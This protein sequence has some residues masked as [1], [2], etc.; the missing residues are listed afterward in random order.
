MKED[1]PDSIQMISGGEFGASVG[2][3][4]NWV[5]SSRDQKF[6]G[7]WVV[8]RFLEGVEGAPLSHSASSVR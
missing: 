3:R 1:A 8:V 5:I 7:F 4:Q 6:P 2:E